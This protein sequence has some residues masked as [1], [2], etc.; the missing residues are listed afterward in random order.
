MRVFLA[1]TIP[2]PRKTNQ[3]TAAENNLNNDSMKIYWKMVE[4]VVDP[5]E[6]LR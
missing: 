1:L 4:Y 6:K 2:L 3:Q 5:T